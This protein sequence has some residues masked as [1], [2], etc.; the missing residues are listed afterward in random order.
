MWRSLVLLP[1]LAT[2]AD[3]SPLHCKD[4]LVSGIVK[5][6]GATLVVVVDGTELA[7]ATNDRIASEALAT[8]DSIAL[9]CNDLEGAPKVSRTDPRLV[10][11]LFARE[12]PELRS[13]VVRV[14]GT[15]REPGVRTKISFSSTDPKV[16]P[17][18]AVVGDEGRRVRAVVKAL[19]GEPIDMIPYDTDDA[20]YVANAMGP[21]EVKRII[22]DAESKRMEL[23]VPDAQLADALGENGVRLKLAANLTGWRLDLFSESKVAKVEAAMKREVQS[24]LAKAKLKRTLSEALRRQGW[25]SGADLANA[26][27]DELAPFVGG[28]TAA[29]RLVEIARK[30]Q[31]TK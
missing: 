26:K 9:Y 30:A 25:R 12:V 28:E 13:G 6:T 15:A 20:K 2:A 14:V 23:V 16:D 4:Q 24:L 1:L 31:Q 3:A 8:G 22:V 27:I 11:K 19:G 17:I 18:A 29:K 10:E 7:V 21:A 5:S